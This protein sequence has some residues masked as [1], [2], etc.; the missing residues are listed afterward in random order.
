MV[1]IPYVIQTL[2]G[3]EKIR[4]AAVNIP[5]SVDSLLVVW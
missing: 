3:G 4:L 5:A 1:A 2:M